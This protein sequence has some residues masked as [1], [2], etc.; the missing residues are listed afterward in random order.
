M[1][2]VV[3]LL[4]GTWD[5]SSTSVLATVIMASVVSGVISETE[6][7]KVVLPTPNPPATTIFTEVM[8]EAAPCGAPTL[9]LTESTKHPFEQIK[10]RPSLGILP[11]VDA[12]QAIGS[13]IRD[14]NPSHAQ[15]QP[16]DSGDFRHRSPVSAELQNRLAFRREYGQVTRFVHRRGDQGLNLKLVARLRTAAGDRVGPDQPA[17]GLFLTRTLAPAASGATVPRAGRAAA[18]P[19]VRA[20]TVPCPRP[21]V[22]RPRPAIPRPGGAWRKRAVVTSRRARHRV[23]RSSSAVPKG[24]SLHHA[25]GGRREDPARPLDQKRHLVGHQ[26]QVAGGGGEDRQAGAVA[27][28]HD[29]QDPALHLHHGLHDRAAL[30]DARC[31]LGQAGQTGSDCGELIGSFLREPGRERERQPVR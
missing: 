28:G 16:Q 27:D 25:P 9:D 1:A 17:Y 14:E 4:S 11:L 21:L 19:R 23:L 2:T 26:A 5:R 8:A 30:E 13:H 24:R 20:T 15:R 6:P 18:L 10:I 22:P 12:D 31:A 3:V 7:T 29:D